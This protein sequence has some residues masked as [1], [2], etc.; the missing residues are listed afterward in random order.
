MLGLFSYLLFLSLLV[1][2]FRVASIGR[3]RDR[4]SAVSS[5]LAAR[6]R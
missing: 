1:V 6:V 3:N 2:L 4:L 5:M